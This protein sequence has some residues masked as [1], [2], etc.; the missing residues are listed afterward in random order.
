MAVSQMM[1]RTRTYTYTVYNICDTNGMFVINVDNA[2]ATA[3][4]L[5]GARG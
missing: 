3:P 4:N 1:A 5:D 2:A